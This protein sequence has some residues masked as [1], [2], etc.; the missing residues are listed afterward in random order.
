MAS[1]HVDHVVLGAHDLARPCPCRR[2][3]AA[4]RCGSAT[5]RPWRASA[6]GRAHDDVALEGLQARLREALARL[7][8]HEGAQ[9]RVLEGQGVQLLETGA[10]LAGARGAGQQHLGV[11]A[12]PQ[13]AGA[14]V[15]L[16]ELL[17]T[18]T[19]AGR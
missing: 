15:G 1:W 8:H 7:T 2:R 18:L 6:P 17:R 16:V 11:V 13:L 5:R 3:R 14:A 9:A 12:A 10:A 4:S 19:P